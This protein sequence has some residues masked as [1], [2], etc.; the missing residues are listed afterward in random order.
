M[1]LILFPL[2]HVPLAHDTVI[3]PKTLAQLGTSLVMCL[4]TP[5]MPSSAMAQLP[6]GY[7]F[8]KAY[9]QTENQYQSPCQ[10]RRTITQEYEYTLPQENRK[11]EQYQYQRNPD[12]Q[13]SKSGYGD[14]GYTFNVGS[15]NTIIFK[16]F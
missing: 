2:V 4:V 16:F 7:E 6:P 9:L 11:Y 8:Q 13:T 14:S 15:Q 5:S 3:S 10:N 1:D 12:V